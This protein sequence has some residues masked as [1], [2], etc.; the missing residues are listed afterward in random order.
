MASCSFVFLLL[1]TTL[2][3][4]CI[5]AFPDVTVDS[6]CADN[7]GARAS[8]AHV[9]AVESR[10]ADAARVVLL[11]KVVQRKVSVSNETGSKGIPGEVSW[12]DLHIAVSFDDNEIA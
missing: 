4:E 1:A 9:A 3:L 8:D 12:D 11:Q 10:E 5:V 2:P 7:P 6:D